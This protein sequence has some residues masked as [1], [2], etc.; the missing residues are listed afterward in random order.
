MEIVA[1]Q[2]LDPAVMRRLVA[3]GMTVKRLRYTRFSAKTVKQQLNPELSLAE[4]GVIIQI[5]M[6]TP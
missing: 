6:L 4:Y 5:S 3:E 2:R 1:L